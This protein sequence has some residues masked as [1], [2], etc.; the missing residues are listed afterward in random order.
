MRGIIH[1]T[2]R[3]ARGRAERVEVTSTHSKFLSDAS[4]NTSK[5][6]IILDIYDFLV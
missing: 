1:S 4:K 6:I 5:I 2:A 3:K